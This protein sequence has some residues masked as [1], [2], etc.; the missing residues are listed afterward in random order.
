M[1]NKKA[2]IVILSIFI[3]VAAVAA[4]VY[5][6]VQQQSSQNIKEIA[7]IT[8]ADA[9]LG[10]IEEGQTIVNTKTE[11][12]D[13]GAIVNVTTT[14]DNVY[15][16]FDSNLNVQALQYTEYQIVVK[17]AA[18][19]SGSTHSEGEV[20][21]TLT[22]AA[23]TPAAIT[24]DKLGD[25]SFDFEITTTAKTVLTDQSTASLVTVSAES[26]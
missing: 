2:A 26:A 20:A 10:D 9:A 15:L 13:L 23:P 4:Y 3:L 18:V 17:Y 5:Q 22:I 25:W 21:C 11:V 1:A 6:V 12:P 8:I 19:G 24:L 16:Y 14:K 7:N